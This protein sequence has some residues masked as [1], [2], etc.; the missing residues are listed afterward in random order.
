MGPFKIKI[1]YVP[2]LV[3]FEV[4]GLMFDF[5]LKYKFQ[6][7]ILLGVS[8]PESCFQRET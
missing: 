7:S 2:L 5:F 6:S 4:P 1:I 8:D 3:L